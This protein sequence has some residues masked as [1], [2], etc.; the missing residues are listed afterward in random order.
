M[1]ETARA[2]NIP[3][4]SLSDH[5][6]LPAFPRGQVIFGFA[7]DE[8]D[9]IADNYANM[10]WWLSDTGLNMEIVR[11]EEHPHIPTF[12]ELMLGFV[13][14]SERPSEQGSGPRVSS[15]RVKP[16]RRNQKYKARPPSGYRRQPP[17]YAKGSVRSAGRTG[18]VPSGRSIQ[19][20]SWMDGWVPSGW[21]SGSRLALKAV[22]EVKSV[23]AAAWPKEP[24]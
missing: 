23:T 11:P 4:E 18:Q 24:K 16:E 14:E 17:Q 13:P 15:K 20:R 22:G 6:N 7:G 12:D 2:C 21:S 3:I 8:F 1:E 19:D 10:Q 5:L 9:K